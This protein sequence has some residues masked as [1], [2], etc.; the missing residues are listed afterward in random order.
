MYYNIRDCLSYNKLYHFIVGERGNGKTYSAKKLCID[1]FMKKGTQF[2]W[3][4]RYKTELKKI[5]KF[6]L[7]IQH[8]YPDV[9]FKVNGGQDGGEFL[10]NG[11]V[12]G[13]YA[14]LSTSLYLKSVSFHGVDKIIYDEFLKGKG[15]SNY[16]R[17]E[18][19][20]FLE[21]Y[22][23]VARLRHCRAFFIANAIDF[24]NPY[25]IYFK[26]KPPKN[27]KKVYT[28]NYIY[29]QMTD[30]VE[31]KEVKLQTDFAKMLQEIDSTYLN[32]SL[33]NE[34]LLNDNLL[35]EVP[36]Q[37]VYPYC[38][39]VINGVTYGVWNNIDGKLYIREN[40]QKTL[41]EWFV[42]D[43]RELK[44]D[45][46]MYNNGSRK[47]RNIKCRFRNGELL[48]ETEKIKN[49]IIDYIVKLV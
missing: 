36:D 7:D 41:S 5:K 29:F 38:N 15:Y 18:V 9:E 42:F 24:Y 26:I 6:F 19:T 44:G 27:K 39:F 48:F 8:E 12:A 4:R 40:Y 2:V 1:D 10:I 11:E 13:Y 47:M 33:D 43:K 35:V 22:E 37:N 28:T 49:T 14:P 46:R 45:Y 32:Y 3:I 30:S 23:T 25:F 31:Y 17:D 16:L 34:F 20:V 21:L